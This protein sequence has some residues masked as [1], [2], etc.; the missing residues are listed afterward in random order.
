MNSTLKLVIEKQHLIDEVVEMSGNLL[1]LAK[2]QHELALIL[3]KDN[4][5]VS[6]GKHFGQSSRISNEFLGIIDRL[7]EL[8]SWFFYE[9]RQIGKIHQRIKKMERCVRSRKF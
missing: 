3:E 4:E 8:N 6:F 9:V 7:I 1:S 2:E 5:T